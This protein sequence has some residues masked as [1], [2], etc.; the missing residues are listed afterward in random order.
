MPER[1]LETDERVVLSTGCAVQGLAKRPDRARATFCQ[2]AKMAQNRARAAA[3]K[4]SISQRGVLPAIFALAVDSGH[5]RKGCEMLD[6]NANFWGLGRCFSDLHAKIQSGDLKGDLPTRTMLCRVLMK[7]PLPPPAHPNP[8]YGTRCCQ[9]HDAWRRR[10]V[11]QHLVCR[12]RLPAPHSPVQITSVSP[13][14]QEWVC[15]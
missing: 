2:M 13:Q 10:G 3:R 7:T 5:A 9:A 11:S 15:N 12:E 6:R 14:M 4:M 8:R 1:C